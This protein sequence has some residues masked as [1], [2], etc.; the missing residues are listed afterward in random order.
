MLYYIAKY[1]SRI[2]S[3]V[4]FRKIYF[5]GQNSVKN[6][7]PI[8]FAV[9]HP[10]AFLDPVLAA[11]FLDPIVHFIVRGDIFNSKT[12]RTILAS[13][14][15]YPIFRFRDGYSNLKNNQATMD[16][17]YKTLSEGKNL[18]V[19]A[20]GQ[21]KHEKRL[22]PIQKGTARMAFGAIEK[23]G[24][25]DIVVMPLG[26]NYSDSHRYRSEV[27]M[28]LGEPIYLKDLMPVYKENPRKAVK[29]LTDSI[30]DGLKKL[31]IHIENEDDDDLV[32]Q[33]LDIQRNDIEKKFLP[34]VSS[35]NVLL[36]NEYEAVEIINKM[37][38]EK[39]TELKNSLDDYQKELDLNNCEDIGVTQFE[40]HNF[41]NTIFVILGYVPF[42]L[43]VLINGLPLYLAKRFADDKVKKIEFHS[44]VR[45]GAG[46][47]G[48]LVYWLIFFVIAMLIGNQLFLGL[49]IAAPILGFFA[50]Y[51]DEIL[52]KWKA[53]RKFKSLATEVQTIINK[54]RA[55][56]FK[57]LLA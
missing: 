37:D 44:S 51:Y 32:N 56:I 24:E 15:M 57:T 28:K 3:R 27:M 17:C 40:K 1:L 6:D 41:I 45:Y 38:P 52:K 2:W 11:A 20:E 26:V 50:L 14:K 9:N 10:T 30:S 12:V 34:M 47:V 31:V 33:L 48:Y 4:Y 22:R 23:Y 49:V 43:A 53:A 13:L 16:F 55:A 36:K 54:K 19:L 39:K 25:L 29:Q 5:T 21:T 18:L 7:K 35:S 46:L 42:L 8:I